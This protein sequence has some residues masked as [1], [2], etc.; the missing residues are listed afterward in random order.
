MSRSTH[1]YVRKSHRY[2]GLLLGIQFLLWTAGGLYFSW[3][4]MKEVRG[5]LNRKQPNWLSPDINVVSPS[6]VIQELRK[7]R[8]VDSVLS[9]RLLDVLGKPTWQIRTGIYH[10]HANGTRKLYQYAHLADAESGYIR[11]PLTREEAIVLATQQFTPMA[12]VKKVQY[13]TS[14]PADH[15]YRENTL[16]A[17]AIELDHPSGTRVYVA[18]EMGEVTKFRNNTWRI[19]DFLWMLHTMDYQSR[20]HFGNL[21]LRIFSVFGLVTVFSGFLLFYY[22]GR[23]RNKRRYR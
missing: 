20:D 2:L 3:S 23:S 19:F 6:V 14:V 16:P 18:T 8:K 12:K 4:N 21:L 10:E 22:S 1:Y 7:R 11:G 5:D 9:V 13:F 15:E 17:F